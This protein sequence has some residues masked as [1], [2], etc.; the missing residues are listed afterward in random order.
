MD[1]W[2]MCLQWWDCSIPFPSSKDFKEKGRFS[3]IMLLINEN[4]E[5]PNEI[6]L[7]IF[8]CGHAKQVKP[9]HLLDIKLLLNKLV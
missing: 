8:R 3:H 6:L 7:Y 9:K 2:C 5:I 1:C 4:E